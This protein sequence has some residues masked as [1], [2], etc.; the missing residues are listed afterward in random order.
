[1]LVAHQAGKTLLRFF[2]LLGALPRCVAAVPDAD[3][4]VVRGSRALLL[5][6]SN[7]PRH[8]RLFLLVL[9]R[10]IRLDVRNLIRARLGLAELKDQRLLVGFEPLH[11]VA[12]AFEFAVARCE[13]MPKLVVVSRVGVSNVLELFKRT[14]L[15]LEV[16]KRTRLRLQRRILRTS[17]CAP[18][19]VDLDRAQRSRPRPS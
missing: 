17:G 4:H 1:M 14:C 10:R 5:V 13:L 3:E 9:F 8:R 6:K 11:L 18:D 7:F 2:G 12:Q 15:R 19:V 16:F